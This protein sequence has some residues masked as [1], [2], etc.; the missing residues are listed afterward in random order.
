M[1]GETAQWLEQSLVSE[2]NEEDAV[3]LWMRIQ[4]WLSAPTGQLTTACN[5]G[6]RGISHPYVASMG[7]SHT[8]CTYTQA[9]K[10]SMT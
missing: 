7:I 1:T 6:S 9:G 10:H 3:L 5:S 8:R 2:M 4:V